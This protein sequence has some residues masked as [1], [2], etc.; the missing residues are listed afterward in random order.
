MIQQG[1]PIKTFKMFKY[2]TKYERN[3]RID[4]QWENVKI[5]IGITSFIGVLIYL[6]FDL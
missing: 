5:I 6:I 1:K 4:Q 3:R 2:Q